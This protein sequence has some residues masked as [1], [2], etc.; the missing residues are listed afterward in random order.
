MRPG[1]CAAR[2]LHAVAVLSAPTLVLVASAPA[3]ADSEA[4]GT[5]SASVGW[6]DN[7]DAASASKSDSA[8][9]SVEP[10]GQLLVASPSTVQRLAYRLGINLFLVGGG[11]TSFSNSLSYDVNHTLSEFTDALFSA[12]VN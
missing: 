3:F 2:L 7:Y 12:A 10:G 6:T 5:V 8:F 9:L 4:Q 11:A 1:S